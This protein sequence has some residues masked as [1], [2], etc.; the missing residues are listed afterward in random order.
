MMI[1]QVFDVLRTSESYDF[2][3]PSLLQQM[4]AEGLALAEE[5]MVPPAVP[6]DVLF[7]Q[8]K[9]A[10]MVLLAGRLGA[11]VPVRALLSPYLE[12]T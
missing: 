10:G 12:D 4:Q 5:G 6:M 8:R 2:A 3:D 1:T 11:R 7:I 9:L